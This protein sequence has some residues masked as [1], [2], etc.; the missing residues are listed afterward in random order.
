M[1]RKLVA[2][3]IEWKD[4]AGHKPL[5][6]LGAR[7]VGKT[8]LMKEF[9]RRCFDNVAYVNCDAEP[10]AAHLFTEDYDIDRILF[11]VQ[12]I[13]GVKPEA[14]KTLIIFDEVQQVERGLH[15]L[16]YFDLYG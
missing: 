3:L 2:E 13:T 5:L 10:L 12:T 6:L 4:R 1:E 8:W 9:G 11:S 15:S 7:Q 16:K 14:G